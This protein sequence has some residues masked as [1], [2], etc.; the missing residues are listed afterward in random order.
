MAA[1]IC[2]LHFM[3][4]NFLILAVCV[5]IA[6]VVGALW[7]VRSMSDTND[8]YEE[9]GV[10][11]SSESDAAPVPQTP[12][13]S[14][15]E[16]VQ[17]SY[18]NRSAGYSFEFPADWRA[19]NTLDE[20]YPGSLSLYNFPEPKGTLEI[21]P[22]DYTQIQVHMIDTSLETFLSNQPEETA[23]YDF[24]PVSIGSRAGVKQ[25]VGTVPATTYVFE[26]PDKMKIFTVEIRGK[27]SA[28]A[29]EIAEKILLSLRWI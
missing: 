2:I 24:V 3:K 18:V 19:V 25:Y 16:K 12:G 5:V 17:K 4:K 15:Q 26:S 23:D 13:A 27:H 7:Y 21:W 11:E 22:A 8:A 20:A 28:E 14:V 10:V 6:A 1:C 29:K 9:A